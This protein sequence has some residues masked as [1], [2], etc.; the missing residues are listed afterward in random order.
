MAATAAFLAAL[1]AAQLVVC[2][3]QMGATCEH[4][5]IDT[6]QWRQRV[7]AL[8]NRTTTWYSGQMPDRDD[9]VPLI[10]LHGGE[11]ST[12]LDFR[13]R[14]S[15]ALP[16]GARVLGVAVTYDLHVYNAPVREDY[17]A[18]VCNTPAAAAG[19]PRPVDAHLQT[20]ALHA[21]PPGPLLEFGR[22]Q[23]ITYG[24]ASL[25]TWRIEEF[26]ALRCWGQATAWSSVLINGNDTFGASISIVNTGDGVHIAAVLDV[27]VSVCYAPPLPP[28]SGNSTGVPA[29]P[30]PTPVATA[31]GGE[32]IDV[33][34][35][36]SSTPVLLFA[37]GGVACGLLALICAALLIHCSVAMRGRSLLRSR[38][39][40]EAGAAYNGA[41][42]Y[43]GTYRFRAPKDAGTLSSD[44]NE[45]ENR[46]T[47]MPASEDDEDDDVLAGGG[48]MRAC[49]VVCVARV[50][51][52]SNARAVT[53]HCRRA[54]GSSAQRVWNSDVMTYQAA[55]FQ[56]RNLFI[57]EKR[58]TL[59]APL[60]NEPD[61]F[62]ARLQ[63]PAPGGTVG[64]HVLARCTPESPCAANYHAGGN[65]VSRQRLSALA[66]LFR[67]KLRHANVQIMHGLYTFDLKSD[68]VL[69]EYNACG[70]LD[71]VLH[72]TTVRTQMRPHE[73]V[74][75]MLQVLS[76]LTYL[77]SHDVLVRVLDARSVRFRGS[78]PWSAVIADVDRWA[79]LPDGAA[80][81]STSRT[82]SAHERPRTRF[83]M[84]AIDCDNVTVPLSA[85]PEVLQSGKHSKAADVFAFGML[86]QHVCSLHRVHQTPMPPYA[87]HWTQ[88]LGG[89][90]GTTYANVLQVT[91]SDSSAPQYVQ[92]SEARAAEAVRALVRMIVTNQ[93]RP[94]GAPH[95][96]TPEAALLQ[97]A[98]DVTTTDASDADRVYANACILYL[99]HALTSF[100]S[101]RR[102]DLSAAAFYLCMA[103]MHLLDA[104][105]PDVAAWQF[106]YTGAVV[107]NDTSLTPHL[108][109]MVRQQFE[110]VSQRRRVADRAPPASKKD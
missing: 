33:H 47:S 48:D 95:A 77:H 93:V 69:F 75:L 61:F 4:H 19:A 108:I 76:G 100:Y 13:T 26:G 21:E 54:R 3:E 105:S 85:A 58:V 68:F 86:V 27:N 52:D 83:T 56:Y 107:Q 97:R 16:P 78:G 45:M 57:D 55:M 15:F 106:L 102:Q 81:S 41:S 44:D 20:A 101:D 67:L 110:T 90:A 11:R 29:T 5:M 17:V 82:F 73:R 14:G 103:Q 80:G 74:M 79:V 40:G 49:P 42:S 46:Y 28:P 88:L 63:S 36:S 25:S 66:R 9:P 39:T 30:M 34:D 51:D 59:G 10:A 53:V 60:S 89:G 31:G 18:V 92:H 94:C 96:S 104:V 65:G 99:V 62:E 87:G 38:P 109:G 64:E 7:D 70:S 91:P 8:E 6:S 23:R 24:D 72:E 1:L 50:P 98:A 2:N 84:G 71:D 43:Y 37:L 35:G 32:P 22:V 12:L